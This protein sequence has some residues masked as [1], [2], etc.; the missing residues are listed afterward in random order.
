MAVIIVVMALLCR[1]HN[2]VKLRV[3]P[4]NTTMPTLASGNR[5]D[6]LRVTVGYLD[7]AMASIVAVMLMTKTLVE[8]MTNSNPKQSDTPSPKLLT[9]VE[10]VLE[11]A[12]AQ[13]LVPC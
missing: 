7:A 10:A 11:V 1:V 5:S 8:M 6:K 3:T 2:H 12:A 13:G 4:S 9:K